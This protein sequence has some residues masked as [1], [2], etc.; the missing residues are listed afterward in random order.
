MIIVTRREM[1]TN[2]KI[3]WKIF[4]ELGYHYDMQ[5]GVRTDM[6]TG[7]QTK[8]WSVKEFGDPYF[9]KEKNE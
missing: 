3:S 5:T 1:N 9:N 7:E 2:L 6:R 4:E 8:N